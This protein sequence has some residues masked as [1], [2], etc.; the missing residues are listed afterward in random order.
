MVKKKLSGDSGFS[1][2]QLPGVGP[3]T[4]EK[5]SSAGITTVFD[6]CIRGT[7]ELSELAAIP[8]AKL[9]EM[10]MRSWD[11]VAKSGMCR[12]ARLDLFQLDKY[13]QS[14]PKIK[15]NVEGLDSL[16]GGGLEVEALTEVYG[17]F[18][19]GKTQFC[20]SSVIEAIEQHD[21]DVI[22]I[23][24]ENT[25]DPSRLAEI[26]V[27]RGYCE[28]LEEAKEKYFPKVEF[29]YTPNTD[30]LVKEVNN[31][32]SLLLEKKA[33]LIIL[34]GAVGQFR[35][36]YLGRGKLSGRQQNLNR[37]MGKLANTAFFFNCSV[38]FTNQVQ[39]DP[40]AL[41]F[42]DPIKPIGGNI[43]GH[44]STYRIYFKKAGKKRI[45]RMVD[46]PKAPINEVYFELTDKGVSE[47]EK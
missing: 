2:E 27:A 8:E 19:S 13:K 47:P 46:S 6:I 35:E 22:W 42:M 16:L 25:F 40:S 33:K 20:L 43:V 39:A 29:R 17:E 12:Q 3:A 10:M 4:L 15:L 38:L 14:L 31:L 18:G 9:E 30:M 7:Q 36:E 41:Q 44:A 26:G 21:S 28:T 1:V 23:D 5:F 11:I 45:A 37:F 34:D 24:V 32:S